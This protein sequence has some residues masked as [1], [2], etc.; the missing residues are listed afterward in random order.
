MRVDKGGGTLRDVPVGEVLAEVAGVLGG[1]MSRWRA[2]I[3]ESVRRREQREQRSL[4]SGRGGVGGPGRYGPRPVLPPAVVGGVVPPAAAGVGL[5]GVEMGGGLS[6][7]NKPYKDIDVPKVSRVG[8]FEGCVNVY[9]Y[10]GRCSS[11]SSAHSIVRDGPSFGAFPKRLVNR[12][13]SLLEWES[14]ARPGRR[15]APAAPFWGSLSGEG[16]G[17]SF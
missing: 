10:V 9:V 11:S 1:D 15:P 12:P 5:E 3:A 16:A 13:D 2:M 17:V 6:R 8:G 7:R 14:G 4:G